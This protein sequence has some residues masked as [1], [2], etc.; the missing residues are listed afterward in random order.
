MK[1]PQP[2]Y[3]GSVQRRQEATAAGSIRLLT[4]LRI[5]SLCFLSSGTI[6]TVKPKGICHDDA[7]VPAGLWI[8]LSTRFLCRFHPFPNR[9]HV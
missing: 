7:V 6:D 3:G 2:P 1:F 9:G 4:M 5:L 8:L